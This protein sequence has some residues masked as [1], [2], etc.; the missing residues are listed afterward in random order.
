MCTPLALDRDD[1][2]GTENSGEPQRKQRKKIGRRKYD[3]KY[4]DL[5]FVSLIDDES[6]PFC[7]VCH[8]ALVNGSMAPAKL[9][10]HQEKCHPEL[11]NK[12]RDYL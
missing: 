5:S 1:E 8:I 11:K 10:R 9:I 3:P 12:S 7:V 4:L 6:L 2:S